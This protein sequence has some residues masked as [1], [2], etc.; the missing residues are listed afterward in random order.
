MGIAIYL[1]ALYNGHLQLTKAT[2]HV[3]EAMVQPTADEKAV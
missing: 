3:N 2:F 1:A